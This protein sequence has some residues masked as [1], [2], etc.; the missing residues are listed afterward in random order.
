MSGES[1]D[2][3]LVEDRGA[4]RW[5]TLNRPEA[6]NAFNDAMYRAM[7]TALR[8]AEARDDIALVAITGTGR[9]FSAGQDLAELA[10]DRSHEQRQKDGFG[11][12]IAALEAFPKPLLMAVNGLGV[13]I[14]LTMLLH[15]DLVILSDAA[16][17]KAP[18]VS[19]G[20]TA[21]AGSSYLL[22][23]ILG[24]GQ[25]A[26]LLYTGGWLDAPTAVARGLG[27]KMVPAADLLAEAEAM[28]AVIA[29]QPVAALMANKRLLLAARLDAVR[30]ARA[31]EDAAFAG[32]LGGHAHREATAAFLSRRS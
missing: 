5:L 10:D 28:A 9:A 19:L 22:P 3:L 16:R 26:H 6:L 20:V 13:G 29:A 14:G 7:A 25:S 31:R 2:V 4:V 18:F 1:N 27:L 30:A 11:P 21:E 15:A 23:Q 32:L 8:E 24:W 17:L 12:F